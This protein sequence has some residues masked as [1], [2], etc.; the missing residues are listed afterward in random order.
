MVSHNN[1]RQTIMEITI[2]DFDPAFLADLEMAKGKAPAK[3]ARAGRREKVRHHNTR[4]KGKWM[5]AQPD[6]GVRKVTA[7]GIGRKRH[8]GMDGHGEVTNFSR[9]MIEAYERGEL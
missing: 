3:A 6:K 5:L 1:T 9:A 7:K 2:N 8:D 4:G